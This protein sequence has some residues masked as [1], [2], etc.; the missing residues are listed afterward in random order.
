VES[1]ARWAAGRIS[2]AGSASAALAA[3]CAHGVTEQALV[4]QLL[5]RLGVEQR[6]LPLVTDELLA[7]ALD[8]G[9]QGD[10]RARLGAEAQVIRAAVCRCRVVEQALGWRLELDEHLARR[11][12]TGSYPLRDC[13]T[14]CMVIPGPSIWTEGAESRWRMGL[15]A[16]TPRLAGYVKALTCYGERWPAPV[17]RRHVATS[18]AVVFV[19][20]GAPMELSVGGVSSSFRAF[21]AGV[22]DRPARTGHQGS[23]DGIG[24]HL[25]ALGVPRLLGLPGAELANRCVALDEIFSH[26]AEALADRLSGVATASRRVAL[27]ERALVERLGAAPSL[28]PEVLWVW[29]KLCSQPSMRIADL[30]AAVGW[31]RTRLASRFSEQIGIS[32][33]RFARVVRFEGARRLIAQGSPSLAQVATRAGYY[34]QAHLS[35]DISALAGY[36]PAEL[37]GELASDAPPDP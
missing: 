36:T 1:T 26:D 25:S 32:P 20:W 18:G 30:A 7:R 14:G 31:S 13:E 23:Q 2:K 15:F 27:V 24:V 5:V 28:S 21:V 8:L 11:S 35:R 12:P 16:P 19:T 33:K 3:L 9:R 10:H 37:A 4:G 29:E 6:G 34:D 17:S 22:Q